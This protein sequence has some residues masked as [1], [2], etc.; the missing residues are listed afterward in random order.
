MSRSTSGSTSSDLAKGKN[1]IKKLLYYVQHV[2]EEKDTAS[3]IPDR[4]LEEFI[5]PYRTNFH[6]DYF[7]LSQES[8]RKS[9]HFKIV[10]GRCDQEG[11]NLL[12]SSSNPS[13]RTSTWKIRMAKQP[14]LCWL[15]EKGPRN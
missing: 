5:N 7:G 2:D 9:Q 13:T 11:H 10:N 1:F 14:H 6:T 4:Y 8:K 12:E 15:D 3:E